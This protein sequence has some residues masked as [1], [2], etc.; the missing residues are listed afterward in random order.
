MRIKPTPKRKRSSPTPSTSTSTSTSTPIKKPKPLST[1]TTSS[2]LL[3]PSYP[4]HPTTPS[5]I[6][7]ASTTHTSSHPL[8]ET[9]THAI[10]S[11]TFSLP[12]KPSRALNTLLSRALISVHSSGSS[13]PQPRLFLALSPLA[14]PPSPPLKPSIGRA[15][16]NLLTHITDV[17]LDSIPDYTSLVYSLARPSQTEPTL[18]PHAIPP[19]LAPTLRPYQSR[20]VAWMMARET[21]PGLTSPDHHPAWNPIPSLLAPPDSAP[22]AYFRIADGAL[23]IEPPPPPPLPSGGLLADEMG[24]GKTVEVLA[25]LLARPAPPTFATIPPATGPRSARAPYPEASAFQCSCQSTRARADL[26]CAGC[27]KR[28]HSWCASPPLRDG[29]PWFCTLC[30]AEYQALQNAS[31]LLPAG[32]IR[33]TLIVTPRA[34]LHQWVEEL[35][36][37]STTPLSIFVYAGIKSHGWIPPSILAQYDV[38]LVSFTTLAAEANYLSVGRY[39]SSLRRAPAYPPLFTPLTRVHFWRVI[40]DE[41]QMID[42]KSKAAL[43]VSSVSAQHRW[44]VTGTPVSGGLPDIA[45]TLRVLHVQPYNVDRVFR[46]LLAAPTHQALAKLSSLISEIAWRTP[47]ADV[48]A[49]LSLPPLTT[50]AHVVPFHP[51]E[52]HSYKMLFRR[53]SSTVGPHITRAN[54]KPSDE[55]PKRIQASLLSLRQACSHPDLGSSG[56]TTA[57]PNESNS[58]SRAPLSID[59]LLDNLID[60]AVIETQEAQRLLIMSR[61]GLAGA[62]LLSSPPNYA[63]AA[64]AYRH[65][66]NLA[67]SSGPVSADTL[68][69]LHAKYHLDYV[70]RNASPSLPLLPGEDTLSQDV[71]SMQNVYMGE[72]ANAAALSRI[73]CK[74]ATQAVVSLMPNLG[75]DSRNVSWTNPWWAPL[76]AL[77]DANPSLL[78]SFAQLFLSRSNVSSSTRA[79]L[80]Y[81]FLSNVID[82]NGSSSTSTTTTTSGSSGSLGGH[83]A[84]AFQY[85][86]VLVVDELFDARHKV[87]GAT[88]HRSSTASQ[89]DVDELLACDRC[90]PNLMG[91]RDA[92]SSTRMTSLLM[93]SDDAPS[94]SWCATEKAIK[95]YEQFLFVGDSKVQTQ[96]E[97]EAA[98]DAKAARER[99]RTEAFVESGTQRRV[100]DTRAKSGRPGTTRATAGLALL[101]ETFT[102][103]FARSPG[104]LEAAGMTKSELAEL[105][106]STKTLFARL[107]KELVAARQVWRRQMDE[108]LTRD[109]LQMTLSRIRLAQPGEDIPSSLAH[110]IIRPYALSTVISDYQ[111][112]IRTHESALSSA[113]AQLH[114]LH[115]LRDVRETDPASRDPC[116][117][118]HEPIVKNVV[119]FYCGHLFCTA[120]IGT[121]L[122]TAKSAHRSFIRCPLC[123]VPTNVSEVSFVELNSSSSSSSGSQPAVLP[124]TITTTLVPPTPLP[125]PLLWDLNTAPPPSAPSPGPSQSSKLDAVMAQTVRLLA[126]DPNIKILVFSLYPRLLSILSM[127]LG[128]QGIRHVSMDS[129]RSSA[130]FHAAVTSFRS[131]DANLLLLPLSF[132]ANGINLTEAS[133]VFLLEPQ[134]NAAVEAQAIGRIHRIGQ[135][136]PTYV[137]RFTILHSVEEAVARVGASRLSSLGL[138]RA[139]KA[140]RSTALT[141]G[142]VYEMFKTHLSNPA[143]EMDIES[144]SSSSSSSLQN[145]APELSLEELQAQAAFWKQKVSLPPIPGRPGNPTMLSRTDALR[146]LEHRMTYAALISG[147]SLLDRDDSRVLFLGRENTMAMAASALLALSP[148]PTLPPSLSAIASQQLS[149]TTTAT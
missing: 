80:L 98:L 2:P 45:G 97:K 89:A 18:P 146:A 119:V 132:S 79:P 49:E 11:T 5:L 31:P 124:K 66:L 34:I 73:E 88:L 123:R 43:V 125:P 33:P 16:L 70:L 147:S 85:A 63:A 13:S 106:S 65:T 149:T 9:V 41:A 112:D 81:R 20:A 44:C 57:D 129:S 91:D 48:E 87:L 130:K 122:A 3:P 47:K 29:H 120:C 67:S 128:N 145:Q 103:Y 74:K 51:V 111:N 17:P 109:E 15:L 105:G 35:N 36:R 78:T 62:Y 53:L 56:S 142:D 82:G 40:S 46:A 24:L 131:S 140:A 1:T 69:V 71:D 22:P 121:M 101:C 116:P 99:E 10:L 104:P 52:A 58:L 28:A 14:L 127:V 118:C 50:I 32:S 94:C 75:F 77:L 30:Q 39:S 110:F 95:V 76:A 7:I 126:A 55:L 92:E 107:K 141:V 83:D 148:P 143:A 84:N 135:T 115:R 38:I 114:Y 25:L 27:Q 4:I 61:N 8:P 59:Q 102:L 42:S 133:V 86:I 117:I 68:Q 12:P 144:T 60:R 139:A 136:K 138:A 23:A 6:A 100:Q 19:A 54:A 93:E 37:H 21:T 137:Y 64:A 108:V 26:F 113:S 96:Q 90:N 72:A 134:T